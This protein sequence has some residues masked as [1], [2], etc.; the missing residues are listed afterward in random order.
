MPACVGGCSRWRTWERAWACCRSGK[1]QAAALT[2]RPLRATRGCRSL[3]TGDGKVAT[4]DGKVTE[5][6]LA[7]RRRRPH[8][9]AAHPDTDRLCHHH[10]AGRFRAVTGSSAG[11]PSTSR[12][13][14]YHPASHVTWTTGGAIWTARRHCR[15][16][17]KGRT[18]DG[19]F[20][21]EQ[22]THLV[23]ATPHNP[24]PTRMAEKA[25]RTK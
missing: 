13:A 3:A 1:T 8:G 12:V 9:R 21:L 5:R 10:R 4:G 7:V 19:S 6:T 22:T 17:E 24:V 14:S 23:P 18:P 20:D 16:G 15:M 2:W 25:G 11:S